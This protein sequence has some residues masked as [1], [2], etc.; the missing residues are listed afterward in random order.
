MSS[1]CTLRLS[2]VKGWGCD[3]RRAHITSTPCWIEIYLN[4]QVRYDC[5]LFVTYYKTVYMETSEMGERV[6]QLLVK[7]C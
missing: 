2:F 5:M 4:G 7:V 6:I 3:Y 1:Q